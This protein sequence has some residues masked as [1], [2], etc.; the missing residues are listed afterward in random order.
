MDY[1][2][3]YSK[4]KYDIVIVTHN[5]LMLLTCVQKSKQLQKKHLNFILH[6]VMLIKKDGWA[7]LFYFTIPL[8]VSSPLSVS[9]ILRIFWS[10]SDKINLCLR[11][12]T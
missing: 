2:Y 7:I 5:V 10:R 4:K 9:R 3:H 11:Y 8:S 12:W 6:F 1:N